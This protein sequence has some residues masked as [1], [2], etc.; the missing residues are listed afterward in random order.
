VPTWLHALG[1]GACAVALAV[2]TALAFSTQLHDRGPAG[3]GDNIR[4]ADQIVAANIRPG[5]AVI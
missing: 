4:R 3:H 5:D 1:W 2:V